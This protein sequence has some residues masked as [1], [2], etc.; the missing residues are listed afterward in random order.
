MKKFK[1]RKIEKYFVWHKI[2]KIV[3]AENSDELFDGKY[4][5][6][7]ELTDEIIDDDFLDVEIMKVE[8]LKDE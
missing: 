3:E 8:E 5:V 2:E 7:K 4:Q 6:I 1:I